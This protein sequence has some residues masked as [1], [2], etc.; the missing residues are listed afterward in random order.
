M[1]FP[2]V[3]YGAEKDVYETG[4][5]QQYPIGQRL[6]TPAGDVFR[7]GEIGTTIGVANNLYQAAVP[8]ANWLSQA[9]TTAMAVGDTTITFADGGTS[10]AVDEIA[11]GTIL[12]EETDDLGHIYRVKSN[13]ATAS[14]ETLCRLEDGVTVQVAVAVAA[15]N[16]TTVLKNLWKD[17]VI[18]PAGIN[19]AANVGI[20]RVIIAADAYGWVQTRGVASCLFET[21][22]TGGALLLGN[23][24]R[25][26]N[27][28]AGAVSILDET[29]GDAEYQHVGY[30]L[31]TAPTADFGHIFLTIE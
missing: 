26:A 25:A 8:T 4:T 1:G 7:Y 21:D 16:V 30:A 11:G 13:D 17:V 29:A 31:E 22:A 20:P 28:V 9:L 23:E 24:C 18:S 6:I 10:A 5:F 3:I 19:T 2:A 27:E 15:N 14:S 12:V